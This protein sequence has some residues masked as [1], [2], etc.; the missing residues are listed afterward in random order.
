MG[1]GLSFSKDTISLRIIK[2]VI[3]LEPL[4]I[5]DRQEGDNLYDTERQLQGTSDFSNNSRV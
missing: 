1:S 2:T 4:F 5:C 3:V